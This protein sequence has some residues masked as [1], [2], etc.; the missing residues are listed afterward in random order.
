MSAWLR[1]PLSEAEETAA[2]RALVGATATGYTLAASPTV[3]RSRW[4][5]TVIMLDGAAGTARAAFGAATCSFH[6]DGTITAQIGGRSLGAGEI[7]AVLGR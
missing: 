1:P 2:C 7:A 4:P 6:R 5:H 3:D